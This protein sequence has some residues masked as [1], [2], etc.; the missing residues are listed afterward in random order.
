MTAG[1]QSIPASA[2]AFIRRLT[3]DPRIVRLVLFGSRAVGDHDSRADIDLALSAPELTRRE[4]VRLR[5]E[6]FEARSLYW[7]SLVHLEQTPHDLRVR[8]AEQG[9][10]LYERKEAER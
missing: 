8:I 4:F 3:Q 1:D 5:R 6:A 7:I 9:V 2:Q 10:T